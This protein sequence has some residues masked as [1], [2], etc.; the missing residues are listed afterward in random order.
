MLLTGLTLFLPG[1]AQ[2]TAGSRT[3][4]RAALAVTIGCWFTALLGVL[5]LLL[6]RGP[7][8]SALTQPF[9]LWAVS[10]LLAGLA[11]GWLVLW[12]DTLR[13]I[14]LAGMESRPRWI[15]GIV[16]LLL[17]ALTSGGLAYRASMVHQGR[18]ALAGIFDSGPA[19][20]AEDGRYNFLLMGSDG[21]EE[22]G[23]QPIRPDSIHVVSVNEDSG[24]SILFSIPRNFQ[25][26]QFS[27]DSPLNAVY[28]EGYNCGNECIINFLYPEVHNDH[29]ELYPEADDPGAQ[30]M[31]DA[32]SGTLG[33]GVHGYVMVDMDGFEELI[34]AMG[35]I[36]IE[37]GGF[38]PYRGERPDGSWGDVWFEP[39]TLTLD[40]QDSLS[41]ARSREFSSDYNRIQR[42]QCIQQAMVGQFTPQTL[43]TRFTDIMRV[44]DSMIQTNVPQ[45]QLGSFVDLAADAQEHTPQ[46]LTLGAPDFGSAGDL[47]STYPDFDAIHSRVDELIAQEQADADESDAEEPAQEDEDRTEPES[48][49]D[50]AD[51]EGEP[52]G[53]TPEHDDPAVADDEPA[54]EPEET[55]LPTQPDGSE[56]TAEYL[57]DAQDRGETMILEQAASSNY[58][59]GK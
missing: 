7:L 34:D 29:P 44:S 57:M 27:E 38:V 47:F 11:A 40:G 51:P 22:R 15:V 13:L 35:G 25:N 26:A 1:G 41:Y 39:G 33:L 54:S 55:G 49:E 30:A 24:E 52:P 37:S 18:L 59:C 45:S 9:V 31:M 19:M 53:P 8:L 32:V 56:L 50:A 16:L 17:A 28:P 42:Q 10:I 58:E 43:L 46:R 20:P 23:D 36:T 4:G 12:L 48:P 2:V 14:R 5:L 21:D 6:L 3:L